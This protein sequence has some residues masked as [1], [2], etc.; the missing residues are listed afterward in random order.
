MF[1]KVFFLTRNYSNYMQE[2]VYELTRYMTCHQ[3]NN[4]AGCK[5]FYRCQLLL[6]TLNQSVKRPTNR[7]VSLR[8][9]HTHGKSSA[10]KPIILNY[11]K[12]WISSMC[13]TWQWV[14]KNKNFGGKIYFLNFTTTH[15]NKTPCG[16]R[17]RDLWVC[18]L[19]LHHGERNFLTAI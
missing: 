16:I 4:P 15:K 11:F 1:F 19:K 14:K 5:W 10:Y 2:G 6:M 3:I 18:R 17:T 8:V 12:I 7:A 13:S 9:L